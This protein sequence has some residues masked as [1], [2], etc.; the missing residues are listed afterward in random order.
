MD[1][2]QGHLVTG[3]GKPVPGD[4]S[5]DCS[6]RSAKAACKNNDITP[7]EGMRA[8]TWGIPK[9]ELMNKRKTPDV[10]VKSLLPAES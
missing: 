5:L 3:F 2:S 10:Y 7:K 6:T 8:R 4:L 9:M 1:G